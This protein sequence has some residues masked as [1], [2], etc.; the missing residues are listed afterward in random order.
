MATVFLATALTWCLMI[1][2]SIICNYGR[3]SE[4]TKIL[5]AGAVVCL[6]LM[7]SIWAI[8]WGITTLLA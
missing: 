1:G 4:I 6:A 8:A 2:T 3:P 5:A 7:A